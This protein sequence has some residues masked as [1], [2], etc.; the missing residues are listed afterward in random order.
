MLPSNPVLLVPRPKPVVAASS[1]VFSDLFSGH[2][3]DWWD[4]TTAAQNFTD[5]GTTPV[6]A[7][8]D[9]VYRT[10]G[11]VNGKYLEQSVSG[12]RG[13]WKQTNGL[14]LDNSDDK[15]SS[16]AFSS[17]ITDTTVTFI[18][19]VQMEGT[20]NFQ[21]ICGITVLAGGTDTGTDVAC[22]G[23]IRDS[24]TGNFGAYR[25][26]GIKG[27]Q[28]VSNGSFVLIESQFD[29]TN[30]TMT[31]NGVSGTPVANTPAFGSDFAYLGTAGGS[32][33]N[34]TIKHLVVINKVLSAGEKTAMRA[35]YP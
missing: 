3:G 16:I 26:S 8:D 10:N 27:V 33:G 7:L 35:A 6:S 5:A 13:K 11:R 25:N 1:F 15:Y 18:A 34:C 9:L 32:P 20:T 30:H 4:F 29:G 2:K 22:A 23:I 14:L 21:R 17:T 12:N 19:V 31:V 24:T 28:A